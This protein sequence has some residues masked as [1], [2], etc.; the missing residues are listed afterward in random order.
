[1]LQMEHERAQKKINE[2]AKKAERLEDLK[3]RND[4]KYLQEQAAR[5]KMKQEK[6]LAPNGDSFQAVRKQQENQIR[7]AKLRMY[8]T[9]QQD[10][11]QVK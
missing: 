7:N 4:Q 10:V 8:Q 9:K 5:E 11:K 6:L 3:R 1:M 2:T